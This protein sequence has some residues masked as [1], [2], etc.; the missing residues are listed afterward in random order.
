MEK[1]A[2]ASSVDQD[3]GCH[4]DVAVTAVLQRLASLLEQIAEVIPQESIQERVLK[5]IGA[6]VPQLWEKIAD[7]TQLVL[8]EHIQEAGE[9]VVDILVPP[10]LKIVRPFCG[11]DGHGENC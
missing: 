1:V 7:L 2:A 3:T 10:I 5:Q 9:Q 6:L 11:A 8:H 4:G